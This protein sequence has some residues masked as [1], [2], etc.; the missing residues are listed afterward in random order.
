V[1]IACV[2]ITHLPM[3]A[4]LRRHAALRERPTIITEGHGSK[5]SVLDS[6]PETA[7][8]IPGMPLQEAL[9]RC[10]DATLLQ[11]DESCYR[12]AFDRVIASLSQR[13]PLVEKAGLGCAYVGLDGL[14]AMYGGESRLITSLL[15]AVPHHLNPRI[16]LASGKFPAYVAAL[17]SD[18]GQ[19][20]RVPDDDMAGFLKRLPIDLLP[21]SWDNKAR[22]RRF[23][24]HTIGQLASLSIGSAQ[25]QFGPEGR[26]AWDLANGIDN[27]PLLPHE[28][29]ESVRES[30]TFPSPTATLHTVL[31][32]VETLLGRAF[33]S[34]TLRGRYA[35]M[36]TLEGTV[37]Q[38]PP[39]TRR[40]AFK[41]PVNSKR[42]AFPA[43]K[44]TL[45]TAVLPGP[46]E[47][48]GL[49]LSG[50]TGESGAQASL[51]SDVRRQEQLREM[52]R[53]LEVRLRRKPPIYQVRDIEPW[54]RVP[55]RRQALVQYDP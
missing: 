23:G 30:L 38:R 34:P 41:E 22:L 31:V 11:A 36:A 55:E 15:H 5:Q 19:A 26:T 2:L 48:M 21:L 16:G 10:K 8:V 6:S 32:A 17:A 25:A 50:L 28:P 27:S 1:K 12:A 4:E 42:R 45:E 14:E 33:A 29:E 47:D 13:C 37:M 53:Q 43:L 35:R 24:L 52:M 39:W 49:T 40:F 7:G 9:S 3:K 44:N 18:G 46:L 20:T 51:F 54:S